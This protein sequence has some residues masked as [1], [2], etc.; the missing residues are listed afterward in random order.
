MTLVKSAPKKS[1][2]QKTDFFR[3]GDK[4][5]RSETW[6]TG[7]ETKGGKQGTEK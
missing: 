1:F 4:E 7:W 6:N 5:Q 3:T 2:A